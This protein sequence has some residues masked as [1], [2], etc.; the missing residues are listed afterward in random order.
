MKRKEKFSTALLEGLAEILLM[1]V[2]GA[3]GYLLFSIFGMGER[4]AEE[5]F[6]LLVLAG[7]AVIGI[8][9]A[10]ALTVVRKIFGG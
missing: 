3:M 7:L 9:T 5:N 1:L 8:G 6:E 4:L 2:C 10:A